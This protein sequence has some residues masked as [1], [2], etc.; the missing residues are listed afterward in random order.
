MDP[1]RP[2]FDFLN[3]FIP[4]SEEEFDTIIKPRISL[5]QFK[6]KELITVAGEV[7]RYLNFVIKGLARKYFRNGN[8][9]QIGRAHV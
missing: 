5:R 9:E 7:E 1:L 3:K 6:K 4:L 2:F 8:E